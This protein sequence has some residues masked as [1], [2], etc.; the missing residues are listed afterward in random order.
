MPSLTVG[1][2]DDAFS[3]REIY[4]RNI[5]GISCFLSCDTV[6]HHPRPINRANQSSSDMALSAISTLRLALLYD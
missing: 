4:S 1:I 5:T 3:N 6:R 2:L